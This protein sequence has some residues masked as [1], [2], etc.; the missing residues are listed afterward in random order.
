MRGSAG[1]GSMGGKRCTLGKSCG[2]TCID[3]RERC[4]IELGPEISR[5]MTSMRDFLTKVRD[6]AVEQY[7]VLDTPEKAAKWL[8]EN[9]EDLASWAIPSEYVDWVKQ[10]KPAILT[11][12]VEPG[13]G[14][15]V[16]DRL[17][18][19]KDVIP[20]MQKMPEVREVGT[21]RNG[22]WADQMLK[23]NNYKLSQELSNALYK[24]NSQVFGS[25]KTEVA[26]IFASLG[27]DVDATAKLLEERGQDKFQKVVGMGGLARADLASGKLNWGAAHGHMMKGLGQLDGE[28]VPMNPSGLWKPS[29]QF[30]Q[31]KELMAAAGV[32]KN[33]AAPFQSNG[34][35][36]KYSGQKVADK[37]LEMIREGQPKMVYFGGQ[38]SN[39]MKPRLADQAVQR[40]TFK[41]ESVTQAGKPIVK[42]FEYYLLQ[43]PNGQRTTVVFGPHGGALGFGSNRNIMEGV[44][45]FAKYMNANGEVPKALPSVKVTDVV[46]GSRGQDA[47][48]MVSSARKVAGETQK[49]LMAK[50]VGL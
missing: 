9:K 8:I 30:G 31:F 5:S 44:G 35:W 42:S 1:G 23:A 7:G 19:L 50:G 39:T 46:G 37:V 45:E 20:V 3:A 27:L 11:F 14:V 22:P 49:E 21:G 2:A 15:G 40:G 33:E 4:V 18:N 43:Q 16:S 28:V 41:L 12:G 48:V 29:T 38:E 10:N 47:P 36:Y 6:S 13:V 17:A 34:S 25:G 26:K 24:D 32:P